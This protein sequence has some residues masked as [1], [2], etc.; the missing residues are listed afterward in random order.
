MEAFQTKPTG[1]RSYPP[2][3]ITAAIVAAW[4]AVGLILA[5]SHTPLVVWNVFLALF[6]TD[7]HALVG[8]A[9]F[10]AIVVVGVLRSRRNFVAAGALVVAAALLQ[11]IAPASDQLGTYLSFVGRERAY[12]KIV[13][14]AKAGRLTRD[15][16]G[17]GSVGGIDYVLDRG[18]PLRIAF[19]WAVSSITGSV[20]FMTRR[21]R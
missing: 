1:R 13:A 6:A 14:D 11:F 17:R 21:T 12:D 8:V 7:A 5:V 16:N 10:L 18:P 3:R 2:P 9:I 19:V 20:L 15:S 4:V